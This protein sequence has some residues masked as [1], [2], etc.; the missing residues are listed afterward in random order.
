MTNLQHPTPYLLKGREKVR[1]PLPQKGR[2]EEDRIGKKW[3]GHTYWEECRHQE[4]PQIL[5]P[6]E[7][8]TGE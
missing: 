7:H 6:K 8:G 4:I 1:W 2:E 5:T 3:P